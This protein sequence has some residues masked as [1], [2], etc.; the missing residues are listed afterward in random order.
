MV[1]D[2]GSRNGTQVLGQTLQA[3]QRVS[4]SGETMLVFG[5]YPVL[6]I[7]SAALYK[8]LRRIA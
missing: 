7:E 3:N 5:Y 8:H 4:L 2:N 6:F 1:T